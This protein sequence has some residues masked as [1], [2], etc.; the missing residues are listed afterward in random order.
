MGSGPSDFDPVGSPDTAK[1]MRALRASFLDDALQE[2]RRMVAAMN[3]IWG[4]SG[5]NGVLRLA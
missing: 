5:K 1:A 4:K 2:F 3:T